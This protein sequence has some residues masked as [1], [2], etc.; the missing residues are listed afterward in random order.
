MLFTILIKQ[1]AAFNDTQRIISPHKIEL[2]T[3]IQQI[4]GGI[5]GA[6]AQGNATLFFA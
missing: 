6:Y 1:R 5:M 3:F 2:F 4:D